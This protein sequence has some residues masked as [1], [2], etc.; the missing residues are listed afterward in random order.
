MGLTYKFTLE[1]KVARVN[2]GTD[3]CAMSGFFQWNDGE[4][5]S[6]KNQNNYLKQR[7]DFK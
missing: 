4:I 5:E 1:G 6:F 3:L 7:S 2:T